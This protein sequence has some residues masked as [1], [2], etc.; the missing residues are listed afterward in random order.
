MSDLIGSF[1]ASAIAESFY[2]HSPLT[3]EL[4]NGRQ[5]TIVRLRVDYRDNDLGIFDP[6]EERL[7]D[8][9][10]SNGPFKMRV[11]LDGVKPYIK[12]LTFPVD[13]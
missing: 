7:G 12:G 8:V 13:L 10:S 2:V 9:R 5:E 3:A 11:E 1:R 6:P 4:L